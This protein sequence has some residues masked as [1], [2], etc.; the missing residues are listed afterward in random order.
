VLV[1]GVVV[2]DEVNVEGRGRGL[3]DALEEAQELLIAVARPALGEHS[4]GGDVEGCKQR[5]VVPLRT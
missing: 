5:V 1:G 2:D 3:V 4:S